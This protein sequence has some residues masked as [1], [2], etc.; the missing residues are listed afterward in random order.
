MRLL[1]HNGHSSGVSCLAIAPDGVHLASGGED[2][3]LLL[4]HLPSAR[5]CRRIQHAHASM[6]WSVCFSMEGAQVA[7]SAGDCTVCVWDCRAA[8]SPEEDEA[9]CDA[10]PPGGGTTGTA[11]DM[12]GTGTTIAAT[13]ST[14]PS[15]SHGTKGDSGGGSSSGKKSTR[16]LISRMHT[17]FTPVVETR[18]TRSNVL[19]AAGAFAPST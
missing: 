12:G 9:A 19:L 7:T 10:A 1:C 6:L 2:R 14:S 17:K 15:L 5:M 4:W 16:F 13:T 11:G 18:Y 8:T 3:A